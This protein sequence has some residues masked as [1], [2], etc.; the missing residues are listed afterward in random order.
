MAMKNL[1]AMICLIAGCNAKQTTNCEDPQSSECPTSPSF[2]ASA[3]E[4]K[5][6]S[7]RPLVAKPGQEVT[8]TGVHL[9]S[10]AVL[11]VGDQV[12]SWTSADGARAKFIMPAM[13]RS[14]A[15]AISVGRK[16][17]FT[18][19]VDAAA[20]LMLAD[21]PD[22]VYPIYMATEDEVC[23]GIKFR[24]ANGDPKTGSK[25]CV[26]GINPWDLRA[27]VTVGVVT[28]KLKVNC[29]NRANLTLYNYEGSV[30]SIPTNGSI[31]TG[32]TVDYWDTIDDYNKAIHGLP[33]AVVS[34][35]N[36]DSDCGGVESADGD[37]NVWKDVTTSDGV[38]GP[39]C[40]STTSNCTMQDKIS[41]LWWSKMQTPG[42][43][44][45]AFSICDTSTH[46]G[47]TDWRLPTQ[48]ELMDAY[49]HGIR[50]AASDQWTNGANNNWI[51]EVNMN[52]DFWSATTD[53]MPPAAISQAWT[54]N[55]A[56]G[57]T[58]PVDKATG[59]P[60][61]TSST[62]TTNGVNTTINTIT[63]TSIVCVRP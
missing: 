10:D 40:G 3:S 54:V 33:G 39:S 60:S 25:N 61:T 46:N 22:N 42:T 44:S 57:K 43:W 16:D 41:G 37:S 56:T 49:N 36:S 21:S 30:G 11:R 24:D 35:W 14:G 23:Y 53:S 52:L 1:A 62:T 9:N 4:V 45:Q 48:K 31:M 32:T 38:T 47:Q 15:F 58:K 34:V 29:R 27:G 18:G 7:I 50:S 26:S 19:S 6:T 55:L 12:V 17:Q 13:H 20:K 59:T 63:N 2:G 28:G 51:I 5:V 8:V